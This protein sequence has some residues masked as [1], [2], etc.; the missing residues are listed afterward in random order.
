MSDIPAFIE[1][2]TAS[3]SPQHLSDVDMGDCESH[4][5]EITQS[6]HQYDTYESSNIT[7]QDLSDLKAMVQRLKSNPALIEGKVH[8][9]KSSL[10]TQK[11]SSTAA[12]TKD[13][14][15]STVLPE[16]TPP[17]LKKEIV[18]ESFICGFPRLPVP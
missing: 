10:T 16:V 2:E 15:S 18:D 7:S 3:S 12:T 14:V 11:T 6:Q 17:S 5:D 8:E 4:H 13:G 1:F 9:L